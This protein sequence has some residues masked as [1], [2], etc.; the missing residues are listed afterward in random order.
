[1]TRCRI[2]SAASYYGTL[3]LTDK[4][5]DVTKTMRV[6]PYDGKPAQIGEPDFQAG[7]GCKDRKHQVSR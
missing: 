2:E 3:N 5:I 7:N 6:M 1:M 4:P